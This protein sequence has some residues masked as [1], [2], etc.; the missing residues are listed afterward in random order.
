MRSCKF[1]WPIKGKQ[2]MS[3]YQDKLHGY[4]LGCLYDENIR[5][6]RIFQLEMVIVVCLNSVYHIRCNSVTI[7]IKKIIPCVNLL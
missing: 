6:L 3:K 5:I 4:I 2:I 7:E 1:Q